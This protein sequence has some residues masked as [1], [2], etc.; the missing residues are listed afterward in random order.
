MLTACDASVQDAEPGATP[1]AAFEP[2]ALQT[3]A[4]A[5]FGPLPDVIASADR[6]LTEPRI[7][8]GRT[9]Y[10]DPRLSRGQELSCNS[11][12]DLAS[13]GVDVR[14][15]ALA[16]GTS[17]GHN[18][19][20]GGRNAPTVYNAALHL[21]QFWDG[22]AADVEAQAKGPIL[23][24]IEMNMPD[25]ASVIAVIES[26]PGY[27]PRFEA[28][29]PESAQ[30][31]TYDNLAAAIGAFERVLV[32]PSRF[33]AFVKGDVD[34]LTAAERA[35]LETFL[36]QGCASCHA[37]PGFGGGSYQKLGAAE[38]FDTS[39]PGRAKVTGNEADTFFFKVPS[40]RNIA[41][42]APY[43]H[44]G[45]VRTLPE[46]VRLMARHQSAASLT[47]EQT[48]SIVTFLQALTGELPRER[49]AA[50]VLPQ[51]GPNT[52]AANLH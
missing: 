10:H 23:N 42:T 31:V 14:P 3:R 29:F 28:A 49:I 1:L 19:Q 13:Y 25:A 11:C 9:L 44:D 12:H 48:A 47:E 30:P 46:A 45:S 5:I 22:R 50:P 51:S 15:A 6:P 40:L 43:F 4:Q 38:P 24:P 21:T 32:T 34:A 37:G 26:I 16:R 2:T 39:D 7:E 27:R 33:D 41:R 18:G 52:P 20:F 8:L 17:F 35:G 36:A